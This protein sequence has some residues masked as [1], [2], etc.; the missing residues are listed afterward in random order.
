MPFTRDDQVVQDLD[1]EQV[2][3]LDELA[4]DRRVLRRGLERARGVVV[5]EDDGGGPVGDRIGEGL[6]GVDLA[7]VQKT[8]R[9]RPDTDHLTGP[10]QG[11]REKV[12]LLPVPDHIDVGDREHVFRPRDPEPLVPVLEPPGEF[13]AGK[14]FA[15]LRRPNP[16]DRHE[17]FDGDL[18]LLLSKD[19]PDLGG[20]HQDVPSPCSPA[21]DHGDQVAGRERSGAFPHQ[22]LTRPIPLGD[23]GHAS[24]CHDEWWNR[25]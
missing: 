1:P 16:G 21:D 9:E 12:L 8:D 6:A 13:E 18:V 15:G 14:E 10:V 24:R 19:V 17:V 3:C 23:L 2:P 22:P 7:R 11:D 4:R 20:D 5:H 25:P